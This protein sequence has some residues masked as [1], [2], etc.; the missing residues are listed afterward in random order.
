MLSAKTKS[1]ISQCP[2]LNCSYRN[3]RRDN[4]KNH[5]KS[6]RHK[7]SNVD[8][9]NKIFAIVRSNSLPA[10]HLLS[11]RDGDVVQVPLNSERQKTT[12]TLMPFAQ[13][14]EADVV[15][16]LNTTHSLEEMSKTNHSLMNKTNVWEHLQLHDHH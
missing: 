15:A 12:S 5:L 10:A 13:G 16:N 1:S 4:L 3:F 6:R 7:I 2:L 11:V 14:Q 8:V 9:L